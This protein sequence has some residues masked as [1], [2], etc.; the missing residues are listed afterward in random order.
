MLLSLLLTAMLASQSTPPCLD[1]TDDDK[2]PYDV[3]T[4]IPVQLEPG[5]SVASVIPRVYVTRTPK[6][7]KQPA[8][9]T[10]WI[11]F[12]L[13]RADGSVRKSFFRFN[14]G[15]NVADYWVYAL[16]PCDVNQDGRTDL[17]FYAGD[18]TGDD[19]VVLVNRN[20][21]FRASATDRARALQ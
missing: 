5:G 3:L 10:H 13:K 18:D 19:I 9:E 12:D 15:D 11:A 17:V 1:V 8:R 6:R 14:Y 2:R 7:G 4:P 20:G 21:R 16:V